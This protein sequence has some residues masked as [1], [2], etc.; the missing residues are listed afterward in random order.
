MSPWTGYGATK[1][2]SCVCPCCP[3]KQM[4]LLFFPSRVNVL[5]QRVVGFQVFLA[6]LLL[7][8]LGQS[9][10]VPIWYVCFKFPQLLLLL[11]LLLLLRCRGGPDGKPPQLLPLK[12]T[13]V[14]NIRG[15]GRTIPGGGK[16]LV[17]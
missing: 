4:P 7:L 5:T 16:V 3:P 9:S 1:C 6:S 8:V 14:L 17:H 2:C 15:Q 13:I 10:G 12:Y 11:L